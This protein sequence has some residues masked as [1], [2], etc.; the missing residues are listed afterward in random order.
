MIAYMC[1]RGCRAASQQS[2]HWTCP[3][4]HLEGQEEGHYCVQG[5]VAMLPFA[6]APLLDFNP[7]TPLA[8]DCR[9]VADARERRLH[10][11]MRRGADIQHLWR[12]SVLSCW[13]R[14]M[15]QSSV[16]PE[17][18]RL[19]VQWIPAVVKDISVWTVRPRCSV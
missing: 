6:T 2:C 4:D 14:T 18:R 9:L 12:Q 3:H 5:I 19:I 7:M 10:S 1:A 13:T 15:E 16:E 8:D 17:R 11:H